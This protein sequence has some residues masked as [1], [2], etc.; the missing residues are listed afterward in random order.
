MS[1]VSLEDVAGSAEISYPAVSASE[2]SVATG[3][4]SGLSAGFGAGFGAGY[5]GSSFS[6][7]ASSFSASAAAG[8]SAEA[9]AEAALAA[10][11]SAAAASLAGFAYSSSVEKA[12]LAAG[13]P[14]AVSE[15][16]EIS[17]LGN[18]GIW[19]NKA[20]VNSWKGDIALSAYTINQDANAEVITKRSSQT[21]EYVQELAVRYLR[22]PTPPAPG[23]IIIV[24]EANV[25]T[26]PAPPL[27]IRQ[28]PARP[29]T[30]APLVIREAPP[31]AP[32]S[33]GRKLIT[34]S[35]RRLP[36]PP[37]K[38]IIERL[39][40]LPSK[41]QSVL[42]E[43]WLAYGEVKRKVIFRKSNVRDAIVVKPRNV[44]IQWEAPRV[45]VR[46]EFKF[47]GV[48]QAN[49]AEYVAR[50]GSSLVV[51]SALPAIANE[52]SVP[53]GLVLA[54][55]YKYKEL[56]ELEG[57]V[58]ALG[59]INLEANGLGAYSSY[60]SGLG[61]TAASAISSFGLSAAS[62]ESA[63]AAQGLAAS[64]AVQYGLGS[65]LSGTLSSYSTALIGGASSSSSAAYGGA[66]SGGLSAGAYEF[67]TF[68]VDESY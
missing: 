54:A 39:A 58:A 20:E 60:L 63:S 34:I 68:E 62:F 21:I 1:F 6:S 35:G 36:P 64:S 51:S 53:A 11:A 10:S 19:V 61:V 56:H 32:A 18:R 45:S 67:S 31:V 9:V 15:S 30:P 38:V 5:G 7:S 29:S 2:F 14:I 41:P 24:Q 17:V 27:I 8:S 33:V 40:P 26:G 44:I 43:R 28:Q 12:I 47:L 49:P 22:P 37:R 3:F 66:L 46:K 52:F 13:E 59:L 48:I 25:S 16:E 55:N 65:S 50:Y 23:E 4:G 57:D 42:I